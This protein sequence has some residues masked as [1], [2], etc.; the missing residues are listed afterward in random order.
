MP[1]LY[2]IR[3]NITEMKIEGDKYTNEELIKDLEN[4]TY[5]ADKLGKPIILKSIQELK[6]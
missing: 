1:G 6:Q 4:N 2:G 5:L 3:N